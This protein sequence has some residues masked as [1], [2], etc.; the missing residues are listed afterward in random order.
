MKST[1]FGLLATL[2]LVITNFCSAQ[3]ATEFYNEGIKLKEARNIVAAAEKFKQAIDLNANYSEA[4]YEY[5]WCQND[6]KNYTTSLQSLRRARVGWDHIPKVHFEM[7]YAFEKL[8]LTD[9]AIKSYNRCLE[10]K[11][12]YSGVFRQ[13]G[14]ISYDKEQYETAL[15]YFS[16]YE[17]VVKTEIKDYLYWYRKG[18]M[19]NAVKNFAVAKTALLKSL[20]FKTDYINTY[21][22][23]GFSS[24][25]LKTENEESIGYYKKAIEIDSKNYIPYNGIGEVYRDNYKNI[26][27]A[28]SWYQ[29]SL[30]I[31]AR[32]RKASFGMGY[33]LNSQG[34][35]DEAAAYLKIAIEEDA[36]YVAAYVELGYSNYMLHKN[37]DA[38]TYLN[39]A[40]TLNSKNENA[41]YYAGL[42]YI[43]Q[44]D[45]VKAQQ[46]VD[47][48]NKLSSKNAAGLQTK[49]NAM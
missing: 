43:A 42:V 10:L 9:S 26:P 27:E 21:L 32:E 35:Y 4:L 31:K 49:V 18:F 39:K 33:C 29:K 25:R 13:L 23:L 15:E 14:Y 46:M 5:G 12:D 44:K 34:K 30:S 7:G 24:C 1:R 37:S 38:L 36:S 2:L 45:K 47:L 3:T 40:M 17:A 6:L 20:N 16:K 19:N 8:G 48:L 11:P 41:P 28:M 22:E